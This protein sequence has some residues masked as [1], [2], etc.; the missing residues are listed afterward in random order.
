[1]GRLGGGGGGMGGFN[2]PPPLPTPPGGE[3]VVREGVNNSFF[4]LQTGVG[5]WSTDSDTVWA[6]LPPS[7]SVS[8][9]TVRNV[10]TS[11]KEIG[12]GFAFGL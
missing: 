5:W 3:V 8:G 10:Q 7:L 6:P 2:E 9:T 1:M 4:D 11:G 12:F